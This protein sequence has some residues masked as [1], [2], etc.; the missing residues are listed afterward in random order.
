M[1]PGVWC[2]D[3]GQQEPRSVPGVLHRSPEQTLSAACGTCG[4]GG[5]CSGH[6]WGSSFHNFLRWWIGL[7][8]A[9][10]DYTH[11]YIYTYMFIIVYINKYIYVYASGPKTVLV[12]RS[13][14]LACVR[15][16]WR[17]G[18]GWGGHVKVPCASS[19]ACCYAAQMS[20]SVA[21]LYTWRGGEFEKTVYRGMEKTSCHTGTIDAA[22]SDVK[23]FIPNSLCSKSKDLLLY[24]K[25]WPW[26]H[27]NLHTHLQQKTISTM[28]RLLWKRKKEK[29]VNMLQWNESK[30]HTKRAFCKILAREFG[31]IRL[32]D[33]SV[34]LWRI[35]FFLKNVAFTS[36]V[37]GPPGCI[38]ICIYLY[39]DIVS[40]F[41]GSERD[42]SFM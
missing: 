23:D 40:E 14:L 6:G 25:C 28:K 17:G 10:S 35:F 32:A 41:L 1:E 24:V 3:V 12:N 29:P 9:I 37:S 15:R 4:G 31:T 27:A 38:C 20:G 7:Q 2:G 22:W 16:S 21:S 42:F 34:S 30:T 13:F 19:A 5:E 39:I 36:T 11:I 26:R 33:M 8:I 18:V